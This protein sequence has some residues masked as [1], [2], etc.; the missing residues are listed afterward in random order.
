MTAPMAVPPGIPILGQNTP[1]NG[2]L[3][4]VAVETKVNDKLMPVIR[5]MAEGSY[6]GRPVTLV[7]EIGLP[8]LRQLALTWYETAIGV[9]HDAALAQELVVAA[10]AEP[11][12]AVAFVDRLNARRQ[13]PAPK[14]AA[15]DG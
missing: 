15:S 14:E 5:I 7:G 2:D 6:E 12:Q 13:P 11:A 1:I 9:R 10:K 3:S 4:F 8:E